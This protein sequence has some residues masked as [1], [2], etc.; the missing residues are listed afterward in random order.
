ME[1]TKFSA[2]N[3]TKSREKVDTFCEDMKPRNVKVDLVEEPDKTCTQHGV[4]Y[5]LEPAPGFECSKLFVD[6]VE[7]GPVYPGSA[8]A[9][10]EVSDAEDARARLT[11]LN[12]TQC[13]LSKANL[14]EERQLVS[15][16][17]CSKLSSLDP[18]VKLGGSLGQPLCEVTFSKPLSAEQRKDVHCETNYTHESEIVDLKD[19]KCVTVEPA[20]PDEIVTLDDVMKRYN[21]TS[22]EELLNATDPTGDGKKLNNL[23]KALEWNDTVPIPALLNKLPEFKNQTKV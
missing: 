13:F 12:T 2:I 9:C 18:T 5:Y 4:P 14:T 21:V 1:V 17:R 10:R 11:Y 19:L 6:G 22:M 16:T 23:M 15:E 7:F 20:D 8:T 3:D